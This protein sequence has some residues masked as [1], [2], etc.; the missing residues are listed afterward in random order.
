MPN[1]YRFS[2]DVAYGNSFKTSEKRIAI[3]YKIT[4]FKMILPFVFEEQC[5]IK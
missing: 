1:S 2:S 4:V 5:Q 3:V